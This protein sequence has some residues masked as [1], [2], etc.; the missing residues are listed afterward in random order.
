LS[1]VA[2]GVWCAGVLLLGATLLGAHLLSLPQP[3]AGD[4]VLARAIA[5][6]RGPRER[7]AWMAVHVLSSECG[8]SRGILDHI[9]SGPRPADLAERILL[10]GTD[11]EIEERARARGIPVRVI[12][13]DDLARAHIEA[14]PLL[15]VSDPRGRLVYVGGYTDRK[16]SAA[17]A[18]IDIIA[19][20]RAG[21]AIPP[22]PLF[23]CAV[24]EGLKQA[25]D[26]AGLKRWA[27]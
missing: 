1:R 26:P 11:A 13:A 19:A 14:A 18:D 10:V 7:G 8:C 20:A 23:G 5:A 21:R 12:T 4:P 16:Q 17:I 6:E 3:D 2:F 22:L 24:S 9:F 15:I 27:R 25:A